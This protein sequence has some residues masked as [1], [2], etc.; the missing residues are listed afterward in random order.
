M[1]NQTKGPKVEKVTKGG[2]AKAGK[3]ETGTTQERAKKV[4]KEKRAEAKAEKKAAAQAAKA[5]KKAAAKAEKAQK[6]ETAKAERAAKKQSKAEKAKAVKVAREGSEEKSPVGKKKKLILV[7][8]AVLLVLV[9]AAGVFM[10]VRM[11]RGGDEET[12][13]SLPSQEESSSEAP[14]KAGAAGGSQAPN[15]TDEEG[16]SGEKE[17]SEGKAEKDSETSSGKEGKAEKDSESP[18][19]KDKASSKEEKSEKG[20]KKEEDAAKKPEESEKPSENT[21]APEGE[22]AL[23]VATAEQAVEGSAGTAS[24]AAILGSGAVPPDQVDITNSTPADKPKP[25]Q[26]VGQTGEES[27]GASSSKPQEQKTPEKKPEEKGGTALT[28]PTKTQEVPDFKFSDAS[29]NL[30]PFSYTA[31]NALEAVVHRDIGEY[32]AQKDD[33]PGTQIT[34][35]V[36]C[37]TINQPDGSLRVLAYAWGSRYAIADNT[38]FDYG[39]LVGPCAMDYRY[40]G[41]QYV[42]QKITLARAG[43][44]FESSVR[45]FCGDQTEAADKMVNQAYDLELRGQMLRNVSDYIRKN[46]IPVTFFRASGQVYNKDGTIYLP[47]EL[48]EEEAS[49]SEA[50]SGE[51][52]TEPS[53][54]LEEDYQTIQDMPE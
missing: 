17:S 18:S 10:L 54:A 40:G 47:P 23:S 43:D 12:T 25:G 1:A 19:D 33:R 49:S 44:Q 32:L 13:A 15:E 37:G 16:L 50:E 9:I 11:L 51:D 6:Q 34:S 26:I 30:P 31:S 2:K 24:V 41:G 7:A 21:P 5:E 39:N 42:L 48:L 52:A 22:K 27:S 20:S 28:P 35:V 45:E 4:I 36:I 3:S 38:L 14:V 46:N 8:L 29:L 53:S